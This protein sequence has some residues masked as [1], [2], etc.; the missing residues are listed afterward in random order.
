MVV[1]VKMLLMIKSFYNKMDTPKVN[2]HASI[3]TQTKRDRLL[4]LVMVAK[5]HQRIAEQR[6][7]LYTTQY[8]DKLSAYKDWCKDNAVETFIEE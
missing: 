2:R 1:L 5:E 4:N 6:F 3:K 8:E 7:H